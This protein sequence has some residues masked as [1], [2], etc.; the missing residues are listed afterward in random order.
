MCSASLGHFPIFSRQ[1]KEKE[2]DRKVQMNQTN[3]LIELF[4]LDV[5]FRGPLKVP[6]QIQILECVGVCVYVSVC[7]CIG[8]YV[9]VSVYIC[10]FSAVT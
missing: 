4:F 9:F 3:E 5:F 1:E 7:L 8:V 2:G 10:V 6:T